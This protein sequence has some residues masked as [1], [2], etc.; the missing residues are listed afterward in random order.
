M[1]DQIA[2]PQ[3]H[4]PTPLEQFKD[5]IKG[6][7]KLVRAL[8]R[9][10]D[11]GCARWLAE[12]YA[13]VR[14]N[15]KL[16]QANR[17]SL[18]DAIVS[19]AALGLSVNPLLGEA[20]LIP[21]KKSFKDQNDNWQSFQAVNFQIGKAGLIKLGYR[22]KMIESI[23]TDT[24]YE[25]EP[26]RVQGGTDPKIEH[27]PDVYGQLRTG[28]SKDVVAAYA[29]IFLTGAN[30][31]VFK[32]LGAAELY[33]VAGMSGDPSKPDEWSDVWNN[34]FPAMAE[35]AA[36]KRACKVLPRTDDLRLLHEAIERDTIVEVGKEPP[37]SEYIEQ[38]EA[39]VA[40]TEPAAIEAAPV[41]RKRS[42]ASSV[43]PRGKEPKQVTARARI[44]AAIENFAGRDREHPSVLYAEALKGAGIQDQ[45][46]FEALTDEQVMAVLTWIDAGGLENRATTAAGHE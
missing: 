34:H 28:F 33:R 39:A 13:A 9:T 32:V 38:I 10:D 5:Q 15:P 4:Q 8:L 44:T 24:V 23:H 35:G 7:T 22:S 26:F 31:P 17:A 46:K 27:E 14:A 6:L 43:R 20:W 30:R 2:T 42:A 1:N 41:D 3:P 45:P 25:G 36:L 18:M 12:V 19:A 16:L 29:V 37:P 40:A 21:R 11:S